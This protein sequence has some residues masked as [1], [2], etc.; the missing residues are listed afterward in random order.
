MIVSHEDSAPAA[1]VTGRYARRLTVLL[2]P[3]LQPEVEAI[4]VGQTL[5]PPGGQSD[6]HTHEEGEMFYVISGRGR[7]AVGREEA[8]V[9]AGSAVWGPPNLSHQLINDGAEPMKI[10]W[11][12]CPP[13]REKGIIENSKKRESLK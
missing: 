11:V 10:L 13:G 2:S 9:S 3:A 5:L 4:A 1:E 7:I 6:D 12:L 8:E